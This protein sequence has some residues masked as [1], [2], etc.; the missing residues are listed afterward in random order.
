MNSSTDDALPTTEAGTPGL[1]LYRRWAEQP[2]DG[3]PEISIVIPA[4]NEEWRILPTI[5]AIAVEISKLDRPWE[6]IV[7]DDG[8]SDDTRKL[9]REL[10]LPNLRLIESENTGKGGA[11]RRGMLAAKGDYVLFADA[12][13]STPIE[14]FSQ[15]LAEITEGG[16]DVVVG[17]RAADGADV[18]NKSLLRKVMSAGLN[19]IVRVGF[20]IPISDTQCGFK[21]FTRDAADE[22]FG[23]QRIDGFSFDL[24]ILFLAR[25]R[26][27]KISEVPVAW[28][29][30]PGSTVDPGKVAIQ[31]LKDL[32]RI[33]TW[34]IQG[35]YSTP[36]SAAPEAEKDPA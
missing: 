25:K 6:L 15:L 2:I 30:A 32:V 5:G 22:L 36:R 4:Y 34:S 14:Q 13:Q 11:V 27:M 7:S 28:Y 17:S 10:G 18:A 35:K 26:G 16:A 33:R 1:D 29:D 12:D 20:R 9:V 3:P 23:V 8:S 21:L 24:E 31:F 19:G